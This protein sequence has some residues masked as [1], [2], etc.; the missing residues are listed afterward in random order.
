MDDDQNKPP[1][2]NR[3]SVSPQHSRTEG[4]QDPYLN[5]QNTQT[6]PQ[7]QPQ[8]KPNKKPLQKK[9]KRVRPTKGKTAKPPQFKV[10]KT[11][12]TLN[13]T[14]L[15]GFGILA[16]GLL[17]LIWVG[18]MVYNRFAS[19]SN[20]SQL[21]QSDIDEFKNSSTA[22]NRAAGERPPQDDTPQ[23][24]RQKSISAKAMAGTWQAQMKNG[25]T[26]LLEIR[27]DNY[28]IVVIPDKTSL[29]RFY[30]NGKF[31]IKDDIVVLRSDFKI[32]PPASQRE[33]RYQVLTRGS[34]PVSA[35]IHRGKLIW[36]AP[37]EDVRGIYV[38][39]FH[40]VLNRMKGKVAVWE[41]LK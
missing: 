7:T 39:P 30:S 36:Q 1:Q 35:G 28:R 5:P 17:A 15:I 2:P 6:T 4:N 8:P 18:S 12:I 41:P 3:P 14:N 40:P 38:P 23:Y 32:P 19:P 9:V 27:N 11:K 37:P 16:L 31:E 20:E 33:Y 26:A 29:Q 22:P 10:G 21:S 24:K 34:M 25:G 13:K